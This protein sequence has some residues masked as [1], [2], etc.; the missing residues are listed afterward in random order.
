M[1]AFGEGRIL[2]RARAASA[3]ARRTG[4]VVTGVILASVSPGGQLV[5]PV[6]PGRPCAAVSRGDGHLRNCARFGAAHR[7]RRA[8]FWMARL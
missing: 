2:P 8:H 7:P 1:A 3:T 4:T 6:P 5:W